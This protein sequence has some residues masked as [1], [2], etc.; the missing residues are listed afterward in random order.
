ML[1]KSKTEIKTSLPYCF[2]KIDNRFFRLN[3]TFNSR[4]QFTKIETTPNRRAFS[5]QNLE[6]IRDRWGIDAHSD[7]KIYTDKIFNDIEEAEIFSL[8]IINNFVKKYRY[9][10]ED[11]I[12]M[13]S[14][15]RE[16]LFGLDVLSNGKGI[17]SIPLGG[18][19]KT[20]NPL[21]NHEISNNIEQ[22][23]TE[24]KDIPFY[25]ELLLNAKQY[26]YQTDYRHS[27]LESVIALELVL[28]AFI[29]KKCLEKSI[30]EVEASKYIKDI[31]ITGSMEFVLKLL[32][33]ETLPEEEILQKC[34]GN[35]TIRNKIVHEGRKNVSE[36]EAQDALDYNQRL[37][38]FL[39]KELN[40]KPEA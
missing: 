24:K 11:A 15:S 6:T 17:I 38:Q 37:I 16:D 7:V 2:Y 35:I 12:H 21:L 29:K 13:V 26:I 32:L 34:K 36:R 27:I 14:L 1:T 5:S 22:L 40:K 3:D 33:N 9:F 10:D 8:Q 18:G 23:I 4:V 31:G 39:N 28:Y 25:E 30:S 19:I 20:V